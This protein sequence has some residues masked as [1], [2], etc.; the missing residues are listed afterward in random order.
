[1]KLFIILLSKFI[2]WFGK[3]FGKDII[4]ANKKIKI[5]RLT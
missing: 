3:L 5:K 1:M 2:Y 4:F